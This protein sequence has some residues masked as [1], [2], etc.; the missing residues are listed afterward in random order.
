M[1][2]TTPDAA[3]EAA[4]VSHSS[5]EAGGF[6]AS[7][8]GPLALLNA[9]C[10]TCANLEFTALGWR[11]V[12]LPMGTKDG[13]EEVQEEVARL[14]GGWAAATPSRRTRSARTKTL[15]VVALRDIADGEQMCVHYVP[16]NVPD[17]KCVLCREPLVF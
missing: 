7:V 4:T 17:A 9:A 6:R 5:V 14:G 3:D 10:R 1:L 8:V 16:H 15:G 2:V 11:D 12:T 13:Q